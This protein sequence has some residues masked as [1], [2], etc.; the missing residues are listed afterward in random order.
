MSDHGS[1]GRL[2]FRLRQVLRSLWVRVTCFAGLGF[3]TAVAGWALRYVI[4]DE[5]AG[6]IGADAIGAILSIIASSMLTVTTFSLSI[7]TAAH[8]TASSGTTPRSVRLLAQDGVSQTVLATFMGAF[9]F[10]LVGL[11]M[12]ETELYG[13]GG[14]V[15]LFLVTLLVILIVIVSLL[16]WIDRLATLGLVG[17]TVTRVEEATARALRA[18]LASPWLGAN[19]LR[20]P[21]PDHAT[22]VFPD[23]VGHVQNCDMARLSKLA[24]AAEI[25][26][27]LA[28]M[29]GAL[30]HPT[31]PLCHVAGACDA[32]TRGAIL[33]CFALEADRSFDQDPGFGV[34]VLSEVAQKA[35]SPAVNDPGT[36]EVVL[37]RILRIFA[38]WT[39]EVRPVVTFPRLY[40]PGL[41]AG[42]ILT[43]S[44]RPIARDAAAIASVQATFQQVLLM[45]ARQN[46][47]IFGATA[48]MLSAEAL[49]LVEKHVELQA[50]RDMIATIAGQV[51][52]ETEGLCP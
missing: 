15:I 23:R 19:P 31:A 44:L 35:L 29:P 9:V 7:V 8:A 5:L 50:E 20:G 51:G 10:S 2:R 26:I 6:W 41:E 33:D 16:R 48:R 11:I 32:A 22:A 46:P 45:L 13:E 40:V 42:R 18:R 30:T 4:P 28:V 24:E 21:A 3:A 47:A 38:A 1:I 34:K 49:E 43:D 36:A 27:Y 52:T 37:T 25:R 12:L 39:D 17:D 14:R